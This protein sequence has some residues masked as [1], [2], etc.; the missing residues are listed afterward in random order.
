MIFFTKTEFQNKYKEYA[1]E[2]IEDWKIEA[3]CEIIY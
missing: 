2:E 1:I 3:V